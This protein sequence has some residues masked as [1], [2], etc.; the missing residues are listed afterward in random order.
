MNRWLA[1]SALV[2]AALGA[3]AVVAAGRVWVGYS[4][5][6]HLAVLQLA[7]ARE[8]LA[9]DAVSG[10]ALTEARGRIGYA[11]GFVAD[12]EEKGRTAPVLLALG[13]ALVPA[14]A[15]L[16]RRAT[17][18]RRRPTPEDFR[19]SATPSRRTGRR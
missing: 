15:L 18:P 11:E 1:L 12:A 2:L 14:A 19:A 10:E 13:L 9:G 6:S 8:L 16:H 3:L 7:E 4:R 17:R 5:D